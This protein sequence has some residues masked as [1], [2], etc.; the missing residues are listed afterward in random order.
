MEFTADNFLYMIK[1]VVTGINGIVNRIG[2]AQAADGGIQVDH[3]YDLTDLVLLGTS[4][5][6]AAFDT[7]AYGLKTHA[8]TTAVGEIEFV[9]PR[10]Y[11]EATD[12]FQLSIL[13]AQAAQVTDTNVLITA[14]PYL[15][16]PGSNTLVT[17][18]A[19]T[20]GP[21]TLLPTWYT[22]TLSGQGLKRQQVD[23]IKLTIANNATTGD[24]AYILGLYVTYASCIV[25]YFDTDKSGIDG[26]LGEYG[27]P[28]R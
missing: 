20:V 10:D 19:A 2:G 27:L 4:V 12:Q 14:T 5:A 16:T 23:F 28:L 22:F 9:V 11:D 1:N 13:V 25:S 8:T 21:T 17:G 18:T 6:V 24:E 26:A 15:M 3:Q 7:N